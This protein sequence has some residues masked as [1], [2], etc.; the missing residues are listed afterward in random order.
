M[1]GNNVPT[2]SARESGAE[3]RDDLTPDERGA[4]LA[5][6]DCGVRGVELLDVAD[7]LGLCG[8]APTGTIMP[9]S[10]M[11]SNFGSQGVA[12]R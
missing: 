6:V 2:P 1:T 11:H 5:A 7:A 12:A 4:L 8:P 3:I 9:G 10:F